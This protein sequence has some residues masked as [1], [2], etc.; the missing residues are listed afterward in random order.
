MNMFFSSAFSDSELTFG[1]IKCPSRL[2]IGTGRYADN[3]VIPEVLKAARAD[4]ITVALR[5]AQND[6]ESIMSHIPAGT[7]LLPNTSGARTVEEAVRIAHIAREAGMGTL[8][9]LEVIPDTRYLLPDNHQ[10]VLATQQLAR[11]GFVVLPYVLPDPIIAQ[12]LADAGAS[13]VMPLGAPIGTNA[14][15]QNQSLI[16][17]IIEQ[18]RLPVIVDAGIGLPS[19]AAQAMEMG[20]AAVLLNTA[21]AT[22]QN[23]V[24]MA[25]AFYHA[26]QAGRKAFLAQPRA[27]QIQAQPSSPPTGGLRI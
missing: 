3:R 16:R 9:K 23:P 6:T 11:D 20:A 25:E 14:G 26:V 8:I 19:H 15:L 4:M 2:M 22:A 13:A 24:A 21:I 17:I 1:Q 12:Q 5:R 27:A 7:P 18:S 10:T